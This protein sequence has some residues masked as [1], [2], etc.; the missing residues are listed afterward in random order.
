MDWIA[1]RAVL[2]ACVLGSHA[3]TL[4]AQPTAP[5]DPD[6]QAPRPA[7]TSN[8]RQGVGLRV[9]EGVKALRDLVYAR[10]DDRELK[11]DLYLPAS[12]QPAEGHKPEDIAPVPLIVWVHGG[13]WRGGTKAVC[14][15]LPLTAKGFAAASVEYRFVQDATF[16]AQIH[17]CKGA[18]RWLRA[19][20]DKYRLDPERI[21]VWGASAGGHL[22]ALLG[23]SAGVENAEGDV[24]GNPTFSSRVNAVCDW[25]GPTDLVAILGPDAANADPDNGGRLPPAGTLVTDLMGCWPKKCADLYRLANPISFASKDDPPFLIMHGDA[26]PLVPLAQSEAL[27]AALEKSGVRSRLHVVKG[28]KHTSFRGADLDM[29]GAFFEAELRPSAPAHPPAEKRKDSDKQ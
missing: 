15:A 14:P 28:H 9:P 23:T 29:V 13:G 16:P 1:R 8:A 5:P 20:A 19:N 4:Y 24:G 18:I 7:S 12:A 17:D 21:G 27:H 6:P 25:F 11:L 22:V 26:D 2:G 10:V 3:L